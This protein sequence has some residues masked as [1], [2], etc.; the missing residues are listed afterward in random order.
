MKIFLEVHEGLTR[1]GYGR[2]KY[3][4]QA[5]H[6]LPK[7]DKPNI[8]DIGCG[9]GDPTFC[10]AR[11]SGGNVT[12]IDTHQPF[13]D[14]LNERAKEAGLGDRT[15]AMNMDMNNMDFPN[16]SFDIIWSEG[17]I[18]FIGFKQGIM[19]WKRLLKDGGCIAV[20][21]ACWTKTDPPKGVYDW[22]MKMY[23]GITT[24]ERNAEMVEEADFELLGHIVLPDDA[25]FTEYYEPLGKRLAEFREKYAGN[26]TALAALD[27]EQYEIDM[28]KKYSGWYGSAFFLMRKK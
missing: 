5:Y 19:D 1:Q 8:L 24:V 3:T 23:P 7:F 28:F 14:K 27:T 4:E 6:M 26:K 25:W 20:H 15:H 12:G 13:V 2:D 18:Y 10:L 17:S 21:E 11:T 9:P 22:W 16:K